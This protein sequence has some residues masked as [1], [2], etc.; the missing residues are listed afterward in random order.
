MS[1]LNE[2][3]LLLHI[4]VLA[5]AFAGFAGIG[6]ALGEHVNPQERQLDAGRFSA[7]CAA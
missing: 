5:V 3:E 6:T 7:R 1:T 4:A 2:T